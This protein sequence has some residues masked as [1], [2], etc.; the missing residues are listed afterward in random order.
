[1]TLDA[2]HNMLLPHCQKSKSNSKNTAGK[3]QALGPS[4]LNICLIEHLICHF[5]CPKLIRG[6]QNVI[7]IQV[8][9]EKIV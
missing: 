7:I 5:R 8:N 3:Q 2:A 4:I 1:M 9:F 6:V